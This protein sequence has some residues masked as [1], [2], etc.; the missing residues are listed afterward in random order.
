MA[1]LTKQ[2]RAREACRQ[3]VRAGWERAQAVNLIYGD[4]ARPAS[5]MCT[6]ALNGLEAMIA[7]E[8][9]AGGWDTSA[10]YEFK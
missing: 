9:G 7:S 5:E 6:W 3:E 8:A 2:Q 1:T 4:S 10:E